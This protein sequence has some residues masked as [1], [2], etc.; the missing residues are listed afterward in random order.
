[1]RLKGR[2]NRLRGSEHPY[3]VTKETDSTLNYELDDEVL[4]RWE[5]RA[6]RRIYDK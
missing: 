2:V 4:T 1:M 6:K 5:E 3:F